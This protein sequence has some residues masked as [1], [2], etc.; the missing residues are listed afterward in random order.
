M[1]TSGD[2]WAIDWE[3]GRVSGAI[4]IDVELIGMAI[5]T[6]VGIAGIE[7]IGNS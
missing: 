5:E 4:D 1:L 2:V 7:T 6:R 3:R